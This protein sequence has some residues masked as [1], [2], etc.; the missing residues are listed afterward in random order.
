MAERGRTLRNLLKDHLNIER[1]I[2]DAI[3][4]ATVS[5]LHQITVENEDNCPEKTKELI[6]NLNKTRD[7]SR[8]YLSLLISIKPDEKNPER[9]S[10]TIKSKDK[11]LLVLDVD[12][13]RTFPHLGGIFQSG[14]QYHEKLLQVL[15]AF[16][17]TRP[18]I[19]YVQG[20]SYVA[21]ILLLHM[22]DAWPTFVAFTNI[23]TRYP[24]MPFYAFDEILVRKAM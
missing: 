10:D 13:P 18:D 24:I 21:A 5:N 14:G 17:V 6:E 1:Q 15:Q 22:E 12:I 19:G 8:K 2:F 9:R 7:D 16:A 3:N 23:A 20:M 11:S 4:D